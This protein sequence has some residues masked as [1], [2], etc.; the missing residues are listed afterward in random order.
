MKKL[1]LLP[2]FSIVL[3]GCDTHET[4]KANANSNMATH[5][6]ENK[7][8]DRENESNQYSPDN[9]GKNIRDR[10]QAAQTPLD[11]SESK[12]DRM[13]TQQIRQKLMEDDALSTNAKNIKIITN[14]G[15]VTLR[16]PVNNPEE[17]NAIVRKV[18]MISG[19]RNVNDQI[20]VVQK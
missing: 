9:T 1:L 3:I 4:P 17:K 18:K 10:N 19:I 6:S 5:S 12:P 13:L 7:A 14:D 8:I 15:V 11:Q 20:E 16:G 2:L